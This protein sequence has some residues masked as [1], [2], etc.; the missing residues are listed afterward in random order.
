M[1]THPV[2]A[3]MSDSSCLSSSHVLNFRR[4]L[5]SRKS[6]SI[7]QREREYV[8]ESRA[9]KGKIREHHPNYNL[10]VPGGRG[11]SRAF[12]KRGTATYVLDAI[13]P[14]KLSLMGTLWA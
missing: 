8:L 2:P 14:A 5:N 10:S 6:R 4:V 1:V 7:N 12:I 3:D 13:T 11:G 9:G